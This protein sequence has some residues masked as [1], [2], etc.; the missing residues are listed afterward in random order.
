MNAA[1]RSVILSVM[2]GLMLSDHLGDVHDELMALGGLV[3]VDL[4]GDFVEGWTDE[5]MEAV[6]Q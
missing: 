3:G 5:D 4:E 2:E 6:S 1:D